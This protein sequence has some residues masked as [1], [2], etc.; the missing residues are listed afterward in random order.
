MNTEQRDI[1]NLSKPE[2]T[3]ADPKPKHVGASW[4][5]L[6]PKFEKAQTMDSWLPVP[7]IEQRDQDHG[8]NFTED[9]IQANLDRYKDGPEHD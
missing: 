3:T 8:G 5:W 9:R 7:D 4:N 6:P 2:P 1:A